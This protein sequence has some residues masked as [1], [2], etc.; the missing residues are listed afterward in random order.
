[1]TRDSLC[2][3]MHLAVTFDVSP[4]RKLNTSGSLCRGCGISGYLEGGNTLLSYY[5]I[6]RSYTLGYLTSFRRT[7]LER[8][9]CLLLINQSLPEKHTKHELIFHSSQSLQYT[10]A[11]STSKSPKQISHR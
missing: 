5:W 9:V 3:C 11:E 7:D 10:I 8:H 4:S 1:M 2:I 6:R